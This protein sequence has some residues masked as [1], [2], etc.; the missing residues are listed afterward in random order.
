M[1]GRSALRLQGLTRGVQS[2]RELFSFAVALDLKGADTAEAISR[3]A[4][5]ASVQPTRGFTY[6]AMRDS[7]KSVAVR[8]SEYAERYE[9]FV[10]AQSRP[11]SQ[12]L[13]PFHFLSIRHDRIVA[14]GPSLRRLHFC[15]WCLIH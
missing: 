3:L 15:T 14:A 4:D 5:R 11:A 13:F 10:C 12:D 1:R 9:L 8:V 6:V 7:C 2:V